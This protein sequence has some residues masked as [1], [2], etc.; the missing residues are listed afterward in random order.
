MGP[1]WSPG[2]ENRSLGMPRPFSRFWERP[3]GPNPPKYRPN[4]R[5]QPLLFTFYGGGRSYLAHPHVFLAIV[6]LFR[7]ALALSLGFAGLRFLLYT[8]SVGDIVLNVGMRDLV[9]RSYVITGGVSQRE[10]GRA[11]MFPCRTLS[12]PV[13]GRGVRLGLV[14]SQ[15]GTSGSLMV[16][17]ESICQSYTDTGQSS[18]PSG[19]VRSC[20]AISGSDGFP[21]E[22]CFG[23]TGP[24]KARR[25]AR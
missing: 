22:P 1:E 16:P 24:D 19:L 9:V 10:V 5:Q 13:G 2:P 8:R 23:T 4:S 21:S 17:Y 7:V 14:G 6:G 15:E 20:R 11:L 25:I 3:R 12:D 18:D